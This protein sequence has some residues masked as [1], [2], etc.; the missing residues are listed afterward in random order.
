MEEFR[1]NIAGKTYLLIASLLFLTSIASQSQIILNTGVSPEDMVENIVGEGIEYDN[2]QFTGADIS[3]GLFANGSTT[4]IGLNT[5]IFLCS[6]ASY[7]IPGPNTTGSAGNNNGYPGDPQLTALASQQ[8]YDASVLEFD[9]IPESDTLR[10]RYVFGSEEYPEWVLNL[11]NDVFGYFVTGPDPDGGMYVNKNVALI[12]GT[13]L[14]VSIATINNVMPSYPEYYVDNTGG[15][16]IQYDGFTVVMTA[17]ILVIPCEEYHIKMAVGDAGDGIYDT[18]V[19]IEENSFTSPKIEVTTNLIPTGVG[20]YMVEGCVEADITFKIPAIGW[21]PYTVHYEILGDAENGVDYEEI[22]DSVHIPAGFDSASIHIV[23]LF[24]GIVEGDEMII[25]VITNT[26]GCTTEY[27]T[28]EIII[29]DY[30]ELATATSGDTAVCEGQEASV[31]VNV[32]NGI[33]P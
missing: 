14:P 22:A 21:A 33:S 10:F 18:G 16:T 9:F 8:T 25:F 2:V 4:N 31:W 17:W 27:D 23:P 20:N 12:P 29:L 30:V 24:D 6:G 19:F 3:R 28:V 5:G 7:N 11:Y 26:L 32:I 15:I 1:F 13:Q